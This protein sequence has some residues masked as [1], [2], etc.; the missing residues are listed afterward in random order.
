MYSHQELNRLAAHKAV[1]GLRIARHRADTVT[2]AAGVLRPLAWCDR[3]LVAW[4]RAS[5][6]LKFAAVPAAVLVGR[7]V[8]P[9][10]KTLRTA[11]RWGPVVF[12]LWRTLMGG[13]L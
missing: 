13:R 6:L 11:L 12:G 5:P 2:A 4:R 10:A 8:F 3:A 1:L 9:R 7:T